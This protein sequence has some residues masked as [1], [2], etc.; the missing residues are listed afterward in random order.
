MDALPEFDDLVTLAQQAPDEF[1]R[2]R[3]RFVTGMVD[4]ASPSAQRRL[5]GLQF[6][7]DME[8]RRSISPM[9]A[10]VRVSQMMHHS[11]SELTA[12]LRQESQQDYCKPHSSQ[13][14]VIPLSRLNPK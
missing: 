14:N 13:T 7:I 1:D 2:L 6:Q 4:N 12:L 5:T 9:A 11:L 3:R 10:C 8:R